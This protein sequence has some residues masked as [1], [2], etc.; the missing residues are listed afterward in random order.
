VRTDAAR[1]CAYDSSQ[2][3]AVFL[4]YEWTFEPDQADSNNI[5]VYYKLANRAEVLL[6]GARDGLTKLPRYREGNGND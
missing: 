6:Q 3:T 5:K 2:A 1:P 4:D